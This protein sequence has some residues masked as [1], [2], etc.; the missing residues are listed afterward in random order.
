MRMLRRSRP[1]FTGARPRASRW[2]ALAWSR[3]TCCTS[4]ELAI[5]SSA[6]G[7][8][9]RSR[10]CTAAPSRC[11]PAEQGGETFLAALVGGHVGGRDGALEPLVERGEAAPGGAPLLAFLGVPQVAA[12]M[13]NGHVEQQ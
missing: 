13:L 6:F 7:S 5:S 9:V 3:A 4:S 11:G 1:V 2:I 8:L 10:T 12:Q